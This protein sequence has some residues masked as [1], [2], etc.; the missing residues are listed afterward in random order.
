MKSY[1]EAKKLTKA[2][3]L[4]EYI[5]LSEEYEELESSYNNLNDWAG[6][7]ENAAYEYSK[8]LEEIKKPNNKNNDVSIVSVN[9]FIRQLTNENL[10]N[11][12][13]EEFIQSYLR[14]YNE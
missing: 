4:D 1:N 7:Q 2:E 6:E 11:D 5:K 10:Y 12:K 8:Q 14:Y 9:N 3:L 13:L